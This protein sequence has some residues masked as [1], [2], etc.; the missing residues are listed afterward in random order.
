MAERKRQRPQRGA[1]ARVWVQQ[2]G[3]EG[4]GK[5]VKKD[6]LSLSLQSMAKGGVEERVLV[7]VAL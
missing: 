7:A 1:T 3:G 2:P 6:T 5:T 4:R